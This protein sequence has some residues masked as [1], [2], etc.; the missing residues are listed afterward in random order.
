MARPREF[1]EK[2]AL[3]AIRSTFWDRGYSATSVDDLV[4]ATGLGKGSLYGAFGTKREMFVRALSEYCVAALT[5]A[6]AR[7]HG[8]DAGALGRLHAYVGVMVKGIVNS[9][10][11][12]LLAKAIAELA[13]DDPEIDRMVS[14]FYR[15]YEDVLAGVIRQ[16]KPSRKAGDDDEAQRQASLLV[17]VLRGLES[18]GKG[19]VPAATLHGIAETALA[20]LR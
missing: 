16:S 13:G 6:E 2:E 19:G 17:A 15:R 4:R 20:A 18:M 8:D 10:R 3:A 1:D 5:F 7:L 14:G 12:C 11:G 9:K